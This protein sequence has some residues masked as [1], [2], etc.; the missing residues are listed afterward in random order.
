MHSYNLCHVVYPT[1]MA[2]N[3][4]TKWNYR[5]AMFPC[6]F[7]SFTFYRCVLSVDL[8]LGFRLLRA[9]RVMW[10]LLLLFYSVK[11]TYYNLEV[12]F[13]GVHNK[14]VPVWGTSF[15]GNLEGQMNNKIYF[16]CALK[17]YS[18]YSIPYERI[19]IVPSSYLHRLF[20]G[21]LFRVNNVRFI[22]V[23]SADTSWRTLRYEI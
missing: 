20:L 13:C 18:S 7:C 21:T 22:C 11:N 4:K 10:N 19:L 1:R 9:S 3:T 8:W 14:P 17:F 12:E 6:S 23:V 16:L 15:A 2:Q 5:H